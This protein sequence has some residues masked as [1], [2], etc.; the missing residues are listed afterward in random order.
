MGDVEERV[1]IGGFD[2]L[3]SSDDGRAVLRKLI[4]RGARREGTGACETGYAEE[5]EHEGFM[6]C[7][8][9]EF[10]GV[11]NGKASLYVEARCV[12][13]PDVAGNAYLAFVCA[14][15]QSAIFP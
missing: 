14:S 1:L 10:E 5:F 15:A 8:V 3:V 2:V 9:M 6:V 4:D 13:I 7:A 12:F 11:T